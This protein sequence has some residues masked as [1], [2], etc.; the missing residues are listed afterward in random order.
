MSGP[1]KILL[2]LEPLRSIAEY[3]AGWLLNTQ[4]KHA[5]IRG[6]GHPVL[7]LPGLGGGDMATHHLRTFLHDIGYDAQPWNLGRNLGPREGMPKM[8]AALE[9]RL[10][11]IYIASGN[12]E[13]SIIGWSL[14]GIYA[15]ELGKL[16][17]AITRQ[18]ITLGTPFKA[19]AGGTNAAS[20]YEVLS[21][22]N[23]HKDPN[24]ISQIAIPPTIPFTSIYSKT[25][26][27]V[28]WECS[29]EDAGPTTENIEIIGASHLGLGHNPIVMYIISDRLSKTKQSWNLYTA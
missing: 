9:A 17:P 15:R 13:V 29:I 27:V 19:S 6:D 10:H 25:D 4:L 23:S 21:G 1:S 8:M 24:V 3:G 22:D 18:V 20:L 14:G 11:E 26:G 5:C 12:R 7:I 16:Q 28:H 2:G